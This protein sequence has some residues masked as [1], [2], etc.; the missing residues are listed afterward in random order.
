M[1]V[2]MKFKD[3]VVGM[4]IRRNEPESSMHGWIGTVVSKDIE[5]YVLNWDDVITENGSCHAYGFIQSYHAN[6]FLIETIEPYI[7]NTSA[8]EQSPSKEADRELDFFRGKLDPWVPST[9]IGN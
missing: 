2:H 1:V 6:G 9:R 3:L 4:R 7:E 8:K 5:E